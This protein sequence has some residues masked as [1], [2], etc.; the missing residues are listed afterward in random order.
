MFALKD[1]WE[2]SFFFSFLGIEAHKVGTDAMVLTQGKYVKD[3]LSNVG[4][5]RAK[6]MITLML[7]NSKLSTHDSL[8][9]LNPQLYWSIMGGL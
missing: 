4:M 7:S 3:L 8:E 5:D 6:A 9:F 1:I 2:M